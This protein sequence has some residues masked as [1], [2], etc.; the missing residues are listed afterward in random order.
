M[1]PGILGQDVYEDLGM[2]KAHGEDIYSDVVD[3]KCITFK[4]HLFYMPLLGLIAEIDII[5]PTSDCF[6]YTRLVTSSV[7]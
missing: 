1:H 4:P 3:L 2:E 7:H 5:A 6:V